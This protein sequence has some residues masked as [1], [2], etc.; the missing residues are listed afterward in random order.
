MDMPISTAHARV[1]KDKDGNPQAVIMRPDKPVAVKEI[2]HP[3]PLKGLPT[4]A[5]RKAS[6]VLREYM[7]A[8]AEWE[9]SQAM[10]ELA[11]IPPL[12]TVTTHDNPIPS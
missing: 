1:I 8:Y 12:N 7:D 6:K 4:P 5:T 11:H 3:N 9:H 2:E 10:P